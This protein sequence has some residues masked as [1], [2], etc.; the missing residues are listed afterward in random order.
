MDNKKLKQL[1]KKNKFKILALVLLVV[2]LIVIKFNFT[3]D[4]RN[5]G[6]TMGNS[7][8]TVVG[9][10]K[11]SYEGNKQGI[12]DGI[13][14]ARI[15][16]PANIEIEEKLQAQSKIHVMEANLSLT[17]VMNIGEDKQQKAED[18][19]QKG[20]DKQQKS[21]DK[22]QKEEDNQPK[23]KNKPP[24]LAILYTQ[25]AK[26]DY[27][28]D[29]STIT[30]QEDNTVLVITVN[31]VECETII[32]ND[33]FKELDRYEKEND[34]SE[35]SFNMELASDKEITQKIHEKFDIENNSCKSQARDLAKKQISDLAKLLSVKSVT[36]KFKSK[37][38]IIYE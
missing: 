31:D 5:L 19:Q 1:F 26:V 27:Y 21:E 8:G 6:R 4:A 14:D 7:Y 3:K 22:Q 34:T 13:N 9:N 17:D 33:S 29:L 35:S 18:N 20:E 37:D 15:P 32:D 23:G 24:K 28:I 25:K 36:V 16:E 2:L 38:G 10:S 12:E 11:G 30:V